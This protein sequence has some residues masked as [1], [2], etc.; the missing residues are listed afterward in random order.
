MKG[1]DIYI[2]NQ[3]I[4][5]AVETGIVT[6]IINNKAEIFVS[7]I[8]NRAF[9]NIRW[10]HKKLKYKDVIKI[11]TSEIRENSLHEIEQTDRQELLAK[12]FRLK[13]TLTEEGLLK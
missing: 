9:Q 5:A 7:G 12:Y 6:I 4:S 13:K 1:F 10:L 3:K 11:T 8:D 2:N